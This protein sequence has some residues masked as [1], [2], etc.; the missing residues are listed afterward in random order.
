[1]H[2]ASHTSTTSI[3]HFFTYAPSVYLCGDAYISRLVVLATK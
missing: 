1:M 3:L 2:L